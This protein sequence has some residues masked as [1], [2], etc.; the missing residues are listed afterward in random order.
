MSGNDPV[1]ANGTGS[2]SGGEFTSLRKKVAEFVNKTLGVQLLTSDI[3]ACHELP[4]RKDERVKPMIVSL[5]NTAMKRDVMIG[6]K[7]LKGTCIYVNEQLTQKN[8]ALFKKA[9]DLRKHGNIDSTWPYNGKGL[10]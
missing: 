5:I 10:P 2:Q 8:A 7:N 1:D 4:S 9:R 6:R 3:V